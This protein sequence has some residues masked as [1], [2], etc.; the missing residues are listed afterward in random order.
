MK[1]QL[2]HSMVNNLE[3]ML[4]EES[5]DTMLETSFNVGFADEKDDLFAVTFYLTLKCHMD[6]G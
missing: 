1:I 2:L 3:M 6:C 5:E 4:T